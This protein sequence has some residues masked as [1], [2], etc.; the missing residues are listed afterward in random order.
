MHGIVVLV[1]SSLHE[2]LILHVLVLWLTVELGDQQHCIICKQPA[3]CCKVNYLARSLCASYWECYWE[4]DLD[5]YVLLP[6]VIPPTEWS[7]EGWQ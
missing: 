5:L 6:N 7:T 4:C 1:D 2:K 3:A